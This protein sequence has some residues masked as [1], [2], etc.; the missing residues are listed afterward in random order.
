MSMME[1][2]YP[3]YDQSLSVYLFFDPPAYVLVPVEVPQQLQFAQRAL[4]QDA[5]VE[6]PINLL[7]GH[8]AIGLGVLA[9]AVVVFL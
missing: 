9:G 6:D 3:I 7:D 2:I 8:V 4:R 1:M 5:L